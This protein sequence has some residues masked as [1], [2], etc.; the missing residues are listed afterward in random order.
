[1][2]IRI[3]E[4]VERA[5][6]LEAF[7]AAMI[8]ALA[9]VV[10]A[11][12]AVTAADKRISS[13]SDN[14]V[15]QA[16]DA[17]SDTGRLFF[18]S[19]APT[20]ANLLASLRLNHFLAAVVTRRAHVMTTMGFTGRWLYG[21]KR[22]LDEIVRTMHAA[23]RGGFFVLLN[24]HDGLLTK[25]NYSIEFVNFRLF[26]CTAFLAAR[27]VGNCQQQFVLYQ[28]KRRS[29]FIGFEA[30]K[31]LLFPR[32]QLRRILRD[33]NRRSRINGQLER[34]AAGLTN[35]SESPLHRNDETR[36][37]GSARLQRC[38]RTVHAMHG[39]AIFSRSREQLR[40]QRAGNRKT[41]ARKLRRRLPKFPIRRR[42]FAASFLLCRQRL[43][44]R[45]SLVL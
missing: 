35:Q 31:T 9:A 13:K 36:S 37:L 44:F 22:R 14:F 21:Q 2:A 33:V 34:G 40:R 30:L 7:V 19:P 20:A 15:S 27:Y 18:F 1:M 24:G 38:N 28:L 12:A 3:V 39:S 43:N 45:E 25:S 26:V 32:I 4:P 8:V 11:V 23:L 10:T 17:T 42:C 6:G 5:D 16:T 29:F 41:V